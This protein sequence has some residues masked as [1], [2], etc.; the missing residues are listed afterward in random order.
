MSN[1]RDLEVRAIN[2]SMVGQTAQAALS[3]PLSS[4]T[5]N[6]SSSNQPT[7]HRLSTNGPHP[8]TQYEP[9]AS[10]TQR[11]QQPQRRDSPSQPVN[12]ESEQ[13]SPLQPPTCGTSSVG[14]VD[15]GS[16]PCRFVP[17]PELRREG[18][19]PTVH[20]HIHMRTGTDNSESVEYFTSRNYTLKDNGGRSMSR[21]HPTRST[22]K[23]GKDYKKT[24]A[25]GN[26]G[27]FG[28]PSN[29]L[30]KTALETS[31]FSN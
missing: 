25:N 7:G 21:R 13:R 4:P 29:V 20:E 30:E 16:F 24:T 19:N 12:H 27:A 10:E 11:I 8:Q 5:N 28:Q 14:T 22:T 17:V 6:H 26:V 9:A 1:L 3:E 2:P 23:P 15:W 18:S 31:S